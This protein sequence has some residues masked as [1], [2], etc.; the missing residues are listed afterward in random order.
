MDVVTAFLYG[1]LDE[2]IYIIQLTLFEVEGA[3]Y[4][5]CLLRKASYGL[6]KSPRVWYQTLSEFL[7][8]M[9]FKRIEADHG[10]FVSE[11][12]FIAIY[13]DDLFIISKDILKLDNLQ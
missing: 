10:V 9:G 8:K 6:K 12:M 5:V 7:K 3:E 4:K 2:T 11:D 13:M 1:F